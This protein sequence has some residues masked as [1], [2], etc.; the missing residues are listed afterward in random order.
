[1]GNMI[2]VTA[3]NG[4]VSV[5]PA[6]N[7]KYYEFLNK[8][9][10]KDTDRYKIEDYVPEVEK[11][12]LKPENVIKA[13]EEEVAAKDEEKKGLRKEYD[14]LKVKYDEM[15]KLL[16]TAK[17]D[18]LGLTSSLK[19]KDKLLNEQEGKLTAADEA[20]MLAEKK[21]SELEKAQ[22]EQKQEPEAAKKTTK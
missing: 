18:L 4:K 2:K 8:G 17:K 7:R 22:A 14:A 11:D 20:R 1:M 21:V 9:A 12:A 10:K 5:I 15:D 19:E 3:P 13:L 16:G 6:A